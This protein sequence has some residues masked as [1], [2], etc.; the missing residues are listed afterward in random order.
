MIGGFF[1]AMIAPLIWLIF[2]VLYKVLRKTVS[3][4]VSKVVTREASANLDN[5]NTSGIQNDTIRN[6][7]NAPSNDCYPFNIQIDNSPDISFTSKGNFTDDE[8]TKKAKANFDLTPDGISLDN[9][10]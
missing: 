10:K 8:T 3:Y 4:G 9:N 1:A 6:Q 2:M 7:D 5:K